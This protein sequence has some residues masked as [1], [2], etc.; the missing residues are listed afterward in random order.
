MKIYQVTDR[1]ISHWFT[2]KDHARQI[3]QQIQRA[4]GEVIEIKSIVFPTG[5]RALVQWL[6]DNA[7]RS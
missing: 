6:N 1:G 2:N 7:I 5:K 4:G 3:Q